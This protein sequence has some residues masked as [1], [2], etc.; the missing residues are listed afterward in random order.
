MADNSATNDG[1]KKS[2]NRKKITYKHIEKFAKELRQLQHG[3]SH[4]VKPWFN[5]ELNDQI[6]RVKPS[7]YVE[8]DYVAQKQYVDPYTKSAS[9]ERT[10][11]YDQYRSYLRQNED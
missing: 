9:I 1:N 4:A 10:I 5:Y 11:N 3:T 2:R 8:N 7:S 6:V